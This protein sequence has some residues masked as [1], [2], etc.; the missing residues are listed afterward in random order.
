MDGYMRGKR[1]FLE[2]VISRKKPMSLFLAKGTL[3]SL[4]APQGPPMNRKVVA[5]TDRPYEWV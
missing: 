4:C 3:P 2:L 1:H 5:D